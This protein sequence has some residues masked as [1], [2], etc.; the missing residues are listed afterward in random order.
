MFHQSELGTWKVEKGWSKCPFDLCNLEWGWE[1]QKIH[2]QK[3]TGLVWFML[4]SDGHQWH[5]IRSK[6]GGLTESFKTEH[7]LEALLLYKKLTS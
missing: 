5:V 2:A 6:V 4:T 7:S 3:K 1:G